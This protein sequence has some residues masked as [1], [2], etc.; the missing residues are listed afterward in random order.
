MTTGE[1]NIEPVIRKKVQGSTIYVFLGLLGFAGILLC[2]LAF[3][4]CSQA[5]RMIDE[6]GVGESYRRLARQIRVASA[7]LFIF[8]FGASVFL[9]ALGIEGLW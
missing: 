7:V 5:L 3:L 4:R 9:I 8:W 2:P 6:H 1:H